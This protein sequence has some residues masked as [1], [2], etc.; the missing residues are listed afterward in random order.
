MSP[1]QDSFR[2]SGVRENVLLADYVSN[3][4][5]K[6]ETNA[7][8]TLCDI[9]NYITRLEAVQSRL[10]DLKLSSYKIYDP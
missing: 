5:E 10:T 1:T 2:Q 4:P 7:D 9:S 3:I 6:D 8:G